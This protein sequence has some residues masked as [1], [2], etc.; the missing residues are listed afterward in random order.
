MRQKLSIIIPSLRPYNFSELITNLEVNSDG[1]I[2]IIAVTN[3]EIISSYKDYN[4]LPIKFIIDELKPFIDAQYRTLTDRENTAVIGSSMGG[5]ISFLIS[6]EH[7]EIFSK[8]G[9]MSSSFYYHEDKVIKM[10]MNYSGPKKNI[11]IYIDHG[12]D[13]LVRGQK[14]F[15]TLTAKGYLVGTDMDYFYAPGAEHN[16]KAWADRLERPLLFFFKK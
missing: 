13:G 9:C 11:K 12:E 16:E 7:P 2:E 10:V 5:L 14:M 6:W 1:D 15:C 4:I 8:T 3:E